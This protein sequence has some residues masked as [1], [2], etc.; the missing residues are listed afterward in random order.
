MRLFA[1]VA[2]PRRSVVWI[3]A[4]RALI[5]L[6]VLAPSFCI[7]IAPI[8]SQTETE[9]PQKT[10]FSKNNGANENDVVFRLVRGDDGALLA[11]ET[12][13]L[14]YSGRRRG[15][16]GIERDVV[17]DLVGAVHIAEREYYQSLNELFRNYEV[18]V[19]ELV[20]DGDDVGAQIRKARATRK[21]K[22][23][24]NP[25]NL[26]S[27][28][29]E[30]VG[31][32]L[33]L[34]YQIDGIDYAA[35][36]M[37]RGDCSPLELVMWTITNGDVGEFFL[38]CAA[39]LFLDGDPGTTE[40]GIVAFLCARD[41]RLAAKRFFALALAQ[42]FVDDVRRE[43]RAL[44]SDEDVKIHE[45]AVIHLR[46]K[47]AL[48][49]VRKALDSGETRVAVFFG[50]AH[51]PDLGNRLETEFGLRRDSNPKWIKAW[52]LQRVGTPDDA[53]K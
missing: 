41:K 6:F 30:G 43:L 21:E 23:N 39:R 22:E 49:V 16:D 1:A 15:K 47:K 14:R 44:D 29:Q 31:K 40:G 13:A 38:D 48:A 28:L 35:K 27:Y 10:D 46:D 3:G 9:A 20:A 8:F 45:N 4:R 5:F 19:Y 17:V 25:L 34:E 7:N 18:V 2:A 36:N 51:I 12:S 24:F 26:I 11:L 33:Q 37:R 50:A 52:D 32:A 42:T 53:E